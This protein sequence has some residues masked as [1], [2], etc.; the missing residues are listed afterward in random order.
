MSRF[1]EDVREDTPRLVVLFR[2]SEQGEEFQWGVVGKIPSLTL[3][4][5]VIRTQ[6]E[7]Y[8]P[9]SYDKLHAC[10]EQDLVVTW[11]PEDRQ[12]WWYAHDTMPLYPMLGMLD[13]IRMAILSTLDARRQGN[14][15]VILGPDGRPVPR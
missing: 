2:L 7:L 5:M 8:C 15:Q 13:T 14:Q 12:T 1:T 3:L 11:N 10:P 4:G 6:A 9:K